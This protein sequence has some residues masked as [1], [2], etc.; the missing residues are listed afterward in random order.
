MP[1]YLTQQD[2]V[3][4]IYAE[5]I[6][7]IIRNYLLTYANLAAF[8]VSGVKGRKYKATDTAK[9][10]VWNGVA[11]EEIQNV[12]IVA[13]AIT[14]AISEVKGYLSRYDRTKLFDGTVT[15]VNLKNKVKNI[16]CWHL[17]ILANPNIDVAMFRTAYEDAIAWLR[18]IQKGIVDPEGWV[19]KADDSAT[20]Y[21]ENTSVKL[22]SNDKRT[23]HY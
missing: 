2:L 19:Y 21:N 14:A 5:K 6:T 7:D 16:V 17:I 9:I 13:E 11:Y 18:D 20:D 1:S 4:H 10:Y 15:D 3:T 8:P 22:Y 12:D 23:N